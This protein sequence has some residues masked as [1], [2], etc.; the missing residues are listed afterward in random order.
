MFMTKKEK[1]NHTTTLLDKNDPYSTV[2]AGIPTC[3]DITET[4]KITFNCLYCNCTMYRNQELCNPCMDLRNNG[5]LERV[6]ENYLITYK[7][8]TDMSY[9]KILKSTL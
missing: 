4:F 3:V 7:K 9:R 5:I 6:R 8:H 2:L 1:T